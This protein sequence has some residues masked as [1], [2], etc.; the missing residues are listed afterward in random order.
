MRQALEEEVFGGGQELVD[1]LGGEPKLATPG[2]D[3]LILRLGVLPIREGQED[4]ALHEHLGQ[5]GAVEEAPRGRHIEL[6]A[7]HDLEAGIT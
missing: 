2:P 7:E 1:L 3:E 4:Q 6:V 5:L